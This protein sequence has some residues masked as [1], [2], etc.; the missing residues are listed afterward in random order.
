MLCS[1][2]HPQRAHTH[3]HTHTRTRERARTCSWLQR[4][5]GGMADALPHSS[6]SIPP[7]LFSTLS[8]PSPTFQH[9]PLLSLPLDP[10]GIRGPSLPLCPCLMVLMPDWPAVMNRV[11]RGLRTFPVGGKKGDV[12]FPRFFWVEPKAQRGLSTCQFPQPS[13]LG[14]IMTFSFQ[15]GDQWMPRRV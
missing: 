7:P 14:L 15:R 2:P 8:L 9:A 13:F 6:A 4:K 3:T 10:P 12:S 1:L 11:S 5:G